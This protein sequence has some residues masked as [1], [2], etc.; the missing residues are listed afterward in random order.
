MSVHQA[1]IISDHDQ[2]YIRKYIF[3]I[4]YATRIT[5]SETDKIQGSIN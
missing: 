5:K 2:L 1:W 4:T 3:H